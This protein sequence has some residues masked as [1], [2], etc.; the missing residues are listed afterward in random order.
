VKLD[1]INP[2]IHLRQ[3]YNKKIQNQNAPRISK[4]KCSNSL[5]TKPTTCQVSKHNAWHI[6]SK[7]V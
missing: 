5:N 3:F 7:K 1:L 4:P 2:K 6:I